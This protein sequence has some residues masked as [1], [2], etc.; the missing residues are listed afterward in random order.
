MQI[1]ST[2]TWIISVLAVTSL[3]AS[4]LSYGEHRGF[5]RR[6]YHK[7]NTSLGPSINRLSKALTDYR[8]TSKKRYDSRQNKRSRGAKTKTHLTEKDKKSQKNNDVAGGMLIRNGHPLID[9]QS[10]MKLK[11]GSP[12]FTQPVADQ[13]NKSG[14]PSFTLPIADQVN[15]SGSP[16][17][18]QPVADQVNNS[19]SPS[20]T[21]PIAKQV[22]NLNDQQN[23]RE[24]IFKQLKRKKHLIARDSLTIKPIKTTQGKHTFARTES[25]PISRR[26]EIKKQNVNGLPNFQNIAASAASYLSLRNQGN[27]IFETGPETNEEQTGKNLG[28]ASE[29]GGGD[30]PASREGFSMGLQNTGFDDQSF[31]NEQNP[32]NIKATDAQDSLA[33]SEYMGF[34]NSNEAATVKNNAGGRQT[35]EQSNAGTIQLGSNND[36]SLRH[37]YMKPVHRY[38]PLQHK[39][40]GGVVHRY[41]NP[42]VN[43]NL[44]ALLKGAGGS[45]AGINGG[46]GFTMRPGSIPVQGGI[47][48]GGV[49]AI[50]PIDPNIVSGPLGARPIMNP[51]DLLAQSLAV[52][53]RPSRIVFVNRPVHHIHQMRVPV[54]IRVPG[55]PPPPKLVVISRPVPLPPRRVPVPV[56]VQPPPRLLVF[57]HRP[58]T[59]GE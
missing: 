31:V 55:S 3:V 21:L 58:S 42:N 18:T 37:F 23:S 59:P 47:V 4:S 26:V 20:F 11:S 46:I 51:P 54:A 41:I 57:H 7:T 32:N 56:M 15:N 17:F 6:S 50:G 19:G 9:G 12:S 33:K 1:L 39:Y 27:P 45:V 13:V 53:P 38:F 34:D 5:T 44:G 40:M 30:N 29:I 25:K 48:P 43:G 10:S 24:N 22:K 28:D 35:L 8:Y 52:G 14:S 16:S 2:I 36:P 49:Q